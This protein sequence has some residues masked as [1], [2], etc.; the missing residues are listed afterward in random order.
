MWLHV[1]LQYLGP[2]YL[3]KKQEIF[4]SLG[5]VEFSSGI[6]PLKNNHVDRNVNLYIVDVNSI[7]GQ[8]SYMIYQVL[9]S[10]GAPFDA[11]GEYQEV[12]WP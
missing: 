11:G 5:V 4:L 2:V 1:I 8:G 10:Q 12:A 3:Y 7:T 6:Y 9:T